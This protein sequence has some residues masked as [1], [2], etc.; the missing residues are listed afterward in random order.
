M[1][2][3]CVTVRH[4]AEAVIRN[5]AKAYKVLPQAKTVYRSYLNLQGEGQAREKLKIAVEEYVKSLT[6]SPAEA[7]TTEP[8]ADKN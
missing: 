2:E 7:Q 8:A 6:Q 1:A 5:L 4:E 3:V